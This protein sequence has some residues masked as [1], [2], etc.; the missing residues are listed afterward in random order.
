MT[1]MTDRKY[2]QQGYRES[3]KEGKGKPAEP[4]VPR[5]PGTLKSRTVF[6]CV[7]CGTLLP[8][9]TDVLGQCPKCRAELHSCQQC[10]H[11]APGHRFECTQPVPERITDK[12][13]RNECTFFSLRGTVERETSLGSGHPEDAR[14]AFHDL[15]KK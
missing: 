13:A 4:S 15:F 8:S 9:L 14:R 3:A 2:R 7:D 6:R 1:A 11:F 12:R 10:A 5:T